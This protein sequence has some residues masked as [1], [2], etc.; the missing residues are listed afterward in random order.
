MT[1]EFPRSAGLS[2]T[3]VMAGL[4]CHKLLWW[5]V[6]E[7]TVLELQPNELVQAEMDRGTRVTEIARSYVPGGVMIDLP[8]DAYAERLTLTRRAI[9]DGASVVYEASFPADG[10][11]V[12]VDILRRDTRSFHLIE[13]KSTT[14][15][16]DHHIPDVAVQ[17]YVLRQNGL[18]LVSTEVMHLN[19]E[20]TYPDLSN[21]FVRSDLSF[22]EPGTGQG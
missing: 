15:V 22:R 14:L 8:Y 12:A 17:A 10:V 20:C 18:D 21:L 4:Q 7:P 6:N 3:R 5:M 1:S 2:K 11:Y 13:V 9:E 19:R 16:K